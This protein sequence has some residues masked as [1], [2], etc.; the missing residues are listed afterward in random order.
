MNVYNFSF[1]EEQSNIRVDSFL[2]SKIESMSRTMIQK[3]IREGN[4]HI[5]NRIITQVD[6]KM[7]SHSTISL[8]IP[9]QQALSNVR[10][11]SSLDIRY[12]DDDLIIL[13]KAPGITVHAGAGTHNDTLVDILQNDKKISGTG[14]RPGIVHRLDKWTSGLMIVAKN[15]TSQYKLGE[16]ISKR[17]VNRKY[18]ALAWKIPQ[19]QGEISS[20]IAYDRYNKRMQVSKYDGKT[21]LTYYKLLETFNNVC[22]LIECT[23]H[24]GRTHQIRVH[25]SSIGHS[26]VGDQIYGKN[27]RNI[28]QASIYKDELSSI[29]RQALHAY[30]LD[31][32]HPISGE[33]LEFISEFPYDIQHAIDNMREICIKI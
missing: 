20:N 21:A 28:T 12:E 23:L 6:H 26:I 13:N 29:K 19:E 14:I 18:L 27:A 9:K 1:S 10:V 7:Q 16:Q 4:L 5:D 15:P 8:K 22:S 3:A 32:I 25:M 2:S 30:A 17:E 24:T 11:S 33:K 31:F